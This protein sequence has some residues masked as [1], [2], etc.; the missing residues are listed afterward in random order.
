MRICKIVEFEAAHKLP[1]HGGKCNRV[2]GH[3]YKLEVTVEGGIISNNT[4]T[5]GMVM[6][7]GDLKNLI[8]GNILEYIDHTYLND[9]MENPT[10]E[11][12]ID[13][14]W[15]ILENDI[16]NFCRSARLHKLRLWET[17]NSY[18]EMSI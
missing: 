9:A 3:T 14:I 16:P 4:F 1:H 15:S 6:D 12:L 5:K 17:S 13:Y 18:V 7:F 10:A 2:H 11:N 8:Q